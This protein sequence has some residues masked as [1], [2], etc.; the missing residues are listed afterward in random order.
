M[1]YYDFLKSKEDRGADHGFEPIFMPDFLFDFQK[2]MVGYAVKKGRAA[3]F[4]DC[5]LGKTPQLLVWSQNV[6]EKTNKPVLV[7]T[8]LAVS[9]QTVFE[10]EKF[11]IEAKKSAL[12]RSP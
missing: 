12:C 8:P 9:L 5:G 2:A 6:L 7:L 1:N 11:G 4:E 3:L 10:S